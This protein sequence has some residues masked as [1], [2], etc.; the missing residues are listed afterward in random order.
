MSASSHEIGAPMSVHDELHLDDAEEPARRSASSV[1]RTKAPRSIAVEL[2]EPLVDRVRAAPRGARRSRRAGRTRREPAARACVRRAA[3]LHAARAPTVKPT[4]PRTSSATSQPTPSRGRS[5][6]ASSAAMPSTMKR[7][8]DDV[9][10]V[11]AITT[12]ARPSRRRRRPSA[13]SRCAFT[14]SPPTAAVGVTL[15]TASPAMR[16]RYER[17][18]RDALRGAGGS[19]QRQPSASTSV[20]RR[21]R[22]RGRAAPRQPSARSRSQTASKPAW[23]RAASRASAERRPRR[24]DR[25]RVGSR[26]RGGAAPARRLSAAAPAGGAYARPPP[27]TSTTRSE[28]APLVSGSAP[29]R[30]QSTKCSAASASGSSPAGTSSRRP[31]NC[32][33]GTIGS[34]AAAGRRRRGRA[35]SRRA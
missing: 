22:Q 11:F 20:D 19:V 16:A 25:A 10:A 17:R 13:R 26:R 35:C 3:P 30:M 8:C 15:F 14:G 21:V 31:A 7:L 32:V 27:A 29:V 1:A 2:G 24:R 4:Q 23:C 33:I 9:S 6:R 28:R 34:A 12:D 18:K 5:S